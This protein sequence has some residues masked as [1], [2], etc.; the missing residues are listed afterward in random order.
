MARMARF[1]HSLWIRWG[2]LF[3]FSSLGMSGPLRGW[4]CLAPTGLPSE[5]QWGFLFFIQ[6]R[7]LGSS[8]R[9]GIFEGQ[10][11]VPPCGGQRQLFLPEGI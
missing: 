3:I 8:P 7:K 6:H 5:D 1:F 10:S 4:P 9:N 2:F 11:K